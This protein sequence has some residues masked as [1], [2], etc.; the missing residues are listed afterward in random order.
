MGSLPFPRK[1]KRCLM[2]SLLFGAGYGNRFAL[3]F[4]SRGKDNRCRH[5]CL[6]WCRQPATGR[7]HINRFNSLPDAQI[8]KRCISTSF[9]FGA[10]YGN[11]TRLRGLGSHY[12]SRYTN[13]AWC[14][15]YSRRSWKIQ[16]LFVA[17]KSTPA[18]GRGA[19]S[20][21]RI[22]QPGRYRSWEPVLPCLRQLHRRSGRAV[23]NSRPE[24][25]RGRSG[26]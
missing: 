12:N 11:R 9:L 21:F 6:H 17:A 2:A 26:S 7:L 23:P 4:P 18:K 19:K 22:T 3:S 1:K 25:D 16:P 8:K 14:G 15:Y 5:Q 24:P 20:G 13:P 10:G